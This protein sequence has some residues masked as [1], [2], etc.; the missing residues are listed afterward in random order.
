MNALHRITSNSAALVLCACG[1]YGQQATQG[2]A[3]GGVAAATAQAAY[4]HSQI[5][6]ARMPAPA[7][8]AAVI[9]GEPYSAEEVSDRMQTLADGTHITQ[10]TQI[11]K[12]YRDSEG[13]TRTE[14]P[15]FGGA[16]SAFRDVMVVEINDAVSGF[17]YVLDPYN[18]IAHRFAP[19]EKPSETARYSQEARAVSQGVP[20]PATRQAVNPPPRTDRPDV[21]AESLGKQVIEG[22]SAEGTKMTRTLPVG[23]IGN[24]RPIVSVTESWFSP[25]LKIVVLSKTS[26]PRMGENTMRL[27]NIDRTEPDPALFR[28]PADYQVIDENSDRVEIKVT[29]P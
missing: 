22:V 10:K 2:T 29:R 18:H 25:D 23:A 26:D 8:H 27:Q 20:P 9:A 24:D 13:R 6:I 3:G 4:S 11:S 15:L 7:I 19:P 17:R 28:V 12:R 16:D 1:T 21:S 14:R 5:A